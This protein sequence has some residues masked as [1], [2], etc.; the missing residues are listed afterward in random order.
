MGKRAPIV[1]LYSKSQ[2][3]WFPA[4]CFI[5]NCPVISETNC[6]FWILS[7]SFW[8]DGNKYQKCFVHGAWLQLNGLQFVYSFFHNLYQ[9]LIDTIFH[10]D[11]WLLCAK[12][13]FYISD[14]SRKNR[15]SRSR[16]IYLSCV[17][18]RPI[19]MCMTKIITW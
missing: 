3:S 12:Y 19:Y 9:V 1:I 14:S 5:G 6:S 16:M 4:T 11:K 17:D 8:C 15:R 18:T 13:M 7:T 2:W 10:K